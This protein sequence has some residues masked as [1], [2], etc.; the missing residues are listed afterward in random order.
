M[1][2]TVTITGLDQLLVRLKALPAEVAS[3]N[4]GPVRSAVR[5]A[6]NVI[7]DEM[8]RNMAAE[9]AKPNEVPYQETGRLMKSIRSATGKMRGKGESYKVGVMTSK[10]SS[11]LS[12]KRVGGYMEYGTVK[13]HS[14]APL[15]TAWAAKKDE[16][17]TV[18]TVELE[19]GIAR[20]ERKW[21]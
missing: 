13:Y 2:T 3:K 1:R 11:G 16:A 17:L 8:R 15:R 4:G 5:K 10:Y 6:A 21:K 9:I 19:K 7:R 12:T 18:M 14:N 20:L